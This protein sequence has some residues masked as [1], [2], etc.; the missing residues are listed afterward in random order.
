VKPLSDEERRRIRSRVA[1]L[2]ANLGPFRLFWL[3]GARRVAARSLIAAKIWPLPADARLIGQYAH[4]VGSVA[5]LADLEDLLSR[6]DHEPMA[7]EGV[8]ED[9]AFAVA[10]PRCDREAALAVRDPGP[11]PFNVFD[12]PGQPGSRT[13]RWRRGA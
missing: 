4:G 6:P 7:I 3:P 11:R 8:R 13:R 1:M 5:V 10:A 12:A 9:A 2:L